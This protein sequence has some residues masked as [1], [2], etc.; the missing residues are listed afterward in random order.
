MPLPRRPV[1]PAL[2]RYFRL[3]EIDL[4]LTR[5]RPRLPPAPP[6]PWTEAL[7]GLAIL[8]LLQAAA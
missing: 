3:T 2:R 5:A 7:I 4:R 6:L 1:P 8:M